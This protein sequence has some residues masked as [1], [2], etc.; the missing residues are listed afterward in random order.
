MCRRLLLIAAAIT[1]SIEPGSASYHPGISFNYAGYSGFAVYPAPASSESSSST[2][3]TSASRLENAPACRYSRLAF[4]SIL[5]RPRR[6][7]TFLVYPPRFQAVRVPMWHR[8][9]RR[10]G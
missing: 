1:A 2:V 7:T 5:L 6:S 9:L 10:P 8:E 4:L 3:T